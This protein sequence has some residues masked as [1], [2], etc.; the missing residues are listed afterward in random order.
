MDVNLLAAGY[1][2]PSKMAGG[3]GIYAGTQGPVGVIM[4]QSADP[5][6]L[7]ATVPKKNVDSSLLQNFLKLKELFINNNKRSQI[8]LSDRITVSMLKEIKFKTDRTLQ[9]FH[10]H[11]LEQNE[12]TQI[13]TNYFTYENEN[14][15]CN[16]EVSWQ[17]E[18]NSNNFASYK[19][20]AYSG[21][22]TFN[23]VRVT[24]IEACGLILCA[25][26]NVSSCGLMPDLNLKRGV[27]ILSIKITARS[28]DLF[29]VPVPSTL[30][31]SLYPLDVAVFTFKSSIVEE[32]N[33]EYRKIEMQLTEPVTDLITF[34]VYKLPSDL[35][36][37]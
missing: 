8:I 12:D 2:N 31:L 22:R 24:H 6:L 4:Q 3:S 32:N 15:R 1:Y 5:K 34:A 11:S 9:L 33:V 27:K 29:S 20:I 14:F 26:N 10:I 18:V 25:E 16:L 37:W 36:S 17:S 13:H 28:H 30:T 21:K 23:R 19:M 35:P 7:I